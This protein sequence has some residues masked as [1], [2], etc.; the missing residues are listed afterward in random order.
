MQRL[1][2]KHYIEW[3]A[4]ILR[5][6]SLVGLGAWLA[7]QGNRSIE[8]GAIL[9][10]GAAWNLGLSLMAL[11]GTFLGGSI[12]AHRITTIAVDIAVANL[13]FF[14]SSAQMQPFWWAGIL[15]VITSALYFAP[16]G[17]V[18]VIMICLASLGTQALLIHPSS[19]SLA[20][21]GLMALVFCLIGSFV[22]I[23]RLRIQTG[24]EDAELAQMKYLQE[25]ERIENER[26]RVIYTLVATLSG[27][28]NYQRVLDTALDSSATAMARSSPA[29]EPIVC[30]VLLFSQKEGKRT[31]L[32]VGS[33]RRFTPADQRIEL[34]GRSGLLGRAIDSGEAS[35]T[36][37][38]SEDTE[39][40]RVIALR[41][42]RVAYCVPIRNGLDTYGVM[43]FAHPDETYFSEE[44]R[45]ILDIV[46]H[47]AMIAI[48]NARLYRDLEQEKE[49]ITE[50]QEEARKKL[51]R[52]L[53]DGPTQSVAALAM[54]VNYARRM[55]ERDIK[56][57]SEE[58]TKVEDLARRTTQE[59]RHMLFT[60]RPLVL[61][62]QG[63]TAALESMAEKMRE[64]FNQMVLLTIDEHVVEQMEMNKQSVVFFIAEEAVNNARKHAGANNVWVRLSSLESDLALLEV[65]D[66]GI[67]FDLNAID[68]DYENRGSL[69]MVNMR[70][71][72]ELVNGVFQVVSSQGGGT[73]IQ[74]LIPLSETASDRL[75]HRQ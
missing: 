43:L 18:V 63:L 57:A 15:P 38:L 64:T 70:E 16:R 73:R 9:I 52:D 12:N 44:R 32:N 39:L 23:A 6:M 51:A 72:T 45:E 24:L 59:L 54:R 1:T 27:T 56:T 26:K 13:L 5:W 20:T 42:C 69:G 65:Q 37:D 30:A 29:A 14:Y 55:M 36:S 7:F 53:H 31:Y 11:Q 22:Y 75:H 50:I 48:Q 28:L 60:L 71:R 34:D 66:D 47:Q 68:A 74:V 62:S 4:V 41:T 33:S 8:V 17:C 19:V 46:G 10:A 67:G 58:L 3:L 35:L 2:T 40:S 49:R 21:F 61:E 25:N